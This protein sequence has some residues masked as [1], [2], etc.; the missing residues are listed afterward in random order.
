MRTTVVI[1]DAVVTEVR[2]LTGGTPLSAF[3]RE[4]VERRVRDLQRQALL[5][6][7]A[8]GYRAEAECPSLD[9]AWAA[10]ETEGL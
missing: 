7:M 9:P 3:V 10:I 4:S 6:E 8:E 1:P 2:R 5:D